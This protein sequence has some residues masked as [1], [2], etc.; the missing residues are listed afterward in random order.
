MR[1]VRLVALLSAAAVTL[2]G[3]RQAAEEDVQAPKQ[4]EEQPAAPQDVA[5]TFDGKGF[6]MNP[7]TIEAAPVTLTFQNDGGQPASAFITKFLPGK[8]PDDLAQV[9]S[10]EDFFQL[11]V[12]AGST[13]EAAPGQSSRLTIQLPEGDY[14]VVG[15]SGQQPATFE[16][17]ATS[18]KVGAPEADLQVDAGDFF[19]KTSESEVAS[20]PLTIELRNVGKQA[21]EM[22]LQKKDGNEGEGVFSLAPPPGGTVWVE[23]ELTPGT[24]EMV[25]FFPDPESGQHHI[26][27]GMQTD[28]TVV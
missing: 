20:G 14:A 5:I 11:I 4:A 12:P 1:A 21:H 17:T 22:V 23:A 19:F 26:D 16:V 9:K 7:A 27:L 8:G 25:C 15:E 13:P 10:E 18:R 28:L 6:S 2:S 24:Y 3:C